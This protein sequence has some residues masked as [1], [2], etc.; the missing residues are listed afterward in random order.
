MSVTPEF[1]QYLP[2]LSVFQNVQTDRQT[3]YRINYASGDPGNIKTILFLHGF[4][5]SSKSWA[6]QFAYFTDY[7]VLAIDA[8]GFGGSD[9]LDDTMASAASELAAVLLHCGIN[10][11]VV[12][13]HSM[14]ECWHKFLEPSIQNFVRVCSCLALTWGERCRKTHRLERRLRSGFNSGR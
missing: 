4:N 8:P 5:G 3:T 10:K 11:V 1:F 2:E 13:G 7:T 6:Y 9:V 14:G 12:V